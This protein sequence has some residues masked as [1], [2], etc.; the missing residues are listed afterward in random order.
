MRT[1]IFKKD[2]DDIE[3][4]LNELDMRDETEILNLVRKYMPEHYK[5]LDELNIEGL[6]SILA[7]MEEM[8]RTE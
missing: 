5:K 1:D 8:R 2:Y 4:L 7:K 3:F 6:R